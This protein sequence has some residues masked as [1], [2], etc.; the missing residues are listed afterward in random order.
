MTS[1]AVIAGIVATG[2]TLDLAASAIRRRR[3]H[4][5]AYTAG[6]AA[7]ATATWALAAGDLTGWT[8]TSYRIFFLFGTVINVML[9]AVG[10]MFLV[11]GKRWGHVFFIIT[12]AISAMA[13][14]LI[15]TVPFVKELPTSGVPDDMWGP[16]VQF[17]PTLFA[18][19]GGAVGGTTIIVLGLVSIVR[20]WR[21]NRRIV[22]GNLLIVAGTLAASTG[23]TQLGFLDETATFE[24][25][26]MLAASLIWAGYRVTSGARAAVPPPPAIV[27]AGPS[28][29]SPERA[30]AELMIGLLERAGYRVIC[31][32]R[33]I[34]DWGN[35]GYTAHEAMEH[36]ERAI[37]NAEAVVVDLHHGYGVVAAGYAHAKEIP[38]LMAAPEGSRIPRPLRG[39]STKQVYY[40]S[41]D[42]VVLAL[43][44]LVPPGTPVVPTGVPE[45]V[46]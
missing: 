2:F 26:L 15:T 33:D 22:W 16:D 37:D 41:I 3:P 27:L 42:D 43:S 7:F 23:G 36:T 35:V 10:S 38:V 39:V 28:I 1:L 44:E 46:T 21:S 29:E 30:H 19:I 31:P 17:G 34:E 32:A 18:V 25:S 4:V 5:T 14:T 8:E 12:G 11:A 40:R 13:T 20:F 6:M 9:L 24:L 45:P